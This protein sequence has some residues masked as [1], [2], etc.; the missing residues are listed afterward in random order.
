LYDSIWTNSKGQTVPKLLT[1]KEINAKLDKVLEEVRVQ[2]SFNTPV[3]DQVNNFAVR[4]VALEKAQPSGW[5]KTAG[6]I[7]HNHICPKQK[8][9]ADW[10][11]AEL[12][13]EI[14]DRLED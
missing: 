1:L 12:A 14:A 13:A 9:L 10:T 4:L 8:T 2:A 3:R 6:A 5:R 11:T 7:Y